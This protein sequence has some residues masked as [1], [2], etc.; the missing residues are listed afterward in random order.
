MALSIK[1]TEK[2]LQPVACSK[3][4][5]Q[6]KSKFICQSTLLNSSQ[7]EKII[8]L[9]F[10]EFEHEAFLQLHKIADAANRKFKIS[11]ALI[12]HR[13][14]TIE[15]S[16]P[17]LMI[18]F[19]ANDKAQAYQACQ[20]AIKKLSDFFPMWKNENWDIQEQGVVAQAS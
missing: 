14:G 11:K 15:S 10:K 7:R 19:S 13:V 17:I 18:A 16:Q 4:L 3:F 12:H 5:S 1:I 20:Y 2:P 8:Q 9:D 6:S